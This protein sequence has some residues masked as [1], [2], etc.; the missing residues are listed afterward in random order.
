MEQQH[1]E[2]TWQSW[3]VAALSR[4]KRMPDLK[5]MLRRDDASKGKGGAELIGMLQGLRAKGIPVTIR[6]VE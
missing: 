5:K 1:N 2:G 6:K 3:H 4:T